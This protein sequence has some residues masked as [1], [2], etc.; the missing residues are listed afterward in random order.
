MYI[1]YIY[2]L[3]LGMSIIPNLQYHSLILGRFPGPPC[4]SIWVKLGVGFATGDRTYL[5]FQNKQVN[6]HRD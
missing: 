5:L 2:I 4:H 6:K 3:N 1:M